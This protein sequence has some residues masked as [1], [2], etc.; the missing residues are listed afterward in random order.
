MSQHTVRCAGLCLSL[1]EEFGRKGMCLLIFGH[2]RRGNPKVSEDG[3]LMRLRE[4]PRGRQTPLRAAYLPARRVG[5]RCRSSNRCGRGRG[6]GIVDAYDLDGAAVAGAILFDDNDAVVGLLACAYARQTNHQH[7][8]SL[9]WCGKVIGKRRQTGR[10][11][12]ARRHRSRQNPMLQVWLRTRKTAISIPST[13]N[14][15]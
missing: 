6:A 4:L 3:Y 5:L 10:A 11:A 8:G 15:K 7:S 14:E 1:R 2:T 9:S 13:G 12:M